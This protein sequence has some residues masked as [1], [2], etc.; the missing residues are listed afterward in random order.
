MKSG[1]TIAF[2]HNGVEIVSGGTD[3]GVTINDGWEQIQ[4]GGTA[5]NDILIG[6]TYAGVVGGTD[7]GLIMSGGGNREYVGSDPLTGAIGAGLSEQTAV[8][9]GSTQYVYAQGTSVD[10]QIAGIQTVSSGGEVIG[11]TILAGGSASVAGTSFNMTVATGGNAT[12]L[13]GAIE[14]VSSG[15]DSGVMLSGGVLEVTTGG[16]ATGD[17]LIAGAQAGVAG[18][19]AIGLSLSD[20]ATE[21]VGF[22]TH[23]RCRG[24]CFF[25]HKDRRIRHSDCRFGRHSHRR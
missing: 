12:I 13:S 25:R 20:G 21:T 14:I 4:T 8:G 11:A 17:M 7:V 2:G 24:R 23:Q 1:G 15:T 6:G 19:T 10:A 3:S 18:G 9:S 16:I 5:F 22:D